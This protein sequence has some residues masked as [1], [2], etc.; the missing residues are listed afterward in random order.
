MYSLRAYL[1]MRRARAL[2][3]LVL[4][5][6]SLLFAQLAKPG[7]CSVEAFLALAAAWALAPAR[8]ALFVFLFAISL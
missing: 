8:A 5:V 3:A 2:A 7:I 1:D 6:V 4:C